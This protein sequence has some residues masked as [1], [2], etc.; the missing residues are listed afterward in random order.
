M[1]IT[2]DIDYEIAEPIIVAVLKEQYEL[3]LKDAPLGF[4]DE[5]DLN[6]AYKLVLEDFMGSKEFQKYTHEIAKKNKKYNSK[7]LTEAE[8]G[9]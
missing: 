5:V 6:E 8:G 3:L 7:R 9:L 1:K 4:E 2:L